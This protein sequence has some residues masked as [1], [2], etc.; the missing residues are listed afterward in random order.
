MLK[1]MLEF[2]PKHKLERYSNDTDT[3]KQL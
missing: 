1:A 3:W 2:I